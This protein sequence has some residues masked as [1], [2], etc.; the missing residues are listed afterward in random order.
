ME[1]LS[2]VAPEIIT[3]SE[4]IVADD[5]VKQSLLINE[6]NDSNISIIGTVSTNEC[7]LNQDNQLLPSISSEALT[8]I[9]E[10]RSQSHETVLG[11]ELI[12]QQNSN[13]TISFGQIMMEILPG[14]EQLEHGSNACL[15]EYQGK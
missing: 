8:E 15:N 13:S 7:L 9:T 6:S 10:P 14:F 2:I 1:Q 3:K 11:L 4:I 5:D 12:H